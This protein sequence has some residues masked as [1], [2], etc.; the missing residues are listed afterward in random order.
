MKK[1][2]IPKKANTRRHFL[3]QLQKQLHKCDVMMS[4][5]LKSE[6]FVYVKY[7]YEEFIIAT[8]RA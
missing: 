1:V 8:E 6:T 5:R 3:P 2:I 7:L 4:G